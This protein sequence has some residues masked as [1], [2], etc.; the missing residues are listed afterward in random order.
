MEPLHEAGKESPSI[1]P[2]IYP[3]DPS[4]EPPPG[5]RQPTTDKKDE[6]I[7]DEQSGHETPRG[8]IVI[9]RRGSDD[10]DDDDDVKNK[11]VINNW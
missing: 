3:P 7:G 10:G 11:F 4:Q 2:H 1:Q 9:D 5:W 8:S 6:P